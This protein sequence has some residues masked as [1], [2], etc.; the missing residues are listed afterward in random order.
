MAYHIHEKYLENEILGADPLKLVR[1]LYRGAID[2]VVNARMH[3]RNG[4][5]RERSRQITRALLIIHELL[6][7]LDHSLD[8]GLSR[9][10]AELYVYMTNRLIEA[11]AKQIDQP[12]AETERLLSTLFEAWSSLPTP[13]L[14][15]PSFDAP[16]PALPE[17]L[18]H[19]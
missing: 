7:A 1:A 17:Y 13:D 8:P 14:P 4:A 3:L 9:P 15:E 10:L 16:D 19:T 6:R 2:A 5:I 11:N 18:S 12:L